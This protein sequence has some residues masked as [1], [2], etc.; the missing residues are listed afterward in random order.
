MGLN[1]TQNMT[2]FIVSIFTV[3]P[4]SIICCRSARRV[5]IIGYDQEPSSIIAYTLR[6]CTTTCTL[7]VT[8]RK[9]SC[10]KVMFSH[11]FVHRGRGL[12][13]HNAMGLAWPPPPPKAETPQ[14]ANSTPKVDLPQKAAPPPPDTVNR[15][16]VRILLECILVESGD[17]SA[18]LRIRAG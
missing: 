5:P 13:S 9:R 4:M 15:W 14:K 2:E 1:T 17:H 12:P 3:T 8:A 6:Y 11:V 18:Q 16:A 7:I 10:R